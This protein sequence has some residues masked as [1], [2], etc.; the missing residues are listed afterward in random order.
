MADQLFGNRIEP[1]CGYCRFGRLMGDGKMILC[2]HAGVV[3][4]YYSCK[5]YRYS[6]LRRVPA[7]KAP[8]LPQFDPSDFEL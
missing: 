4:L 7:K 8:E 3:P 1:A 2:E 5:K 6:P